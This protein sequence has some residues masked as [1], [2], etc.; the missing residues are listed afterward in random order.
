MRIL[1]I[2]PPV[3][4]F[5]YTPVR[6]YPLNLLYLGTI[7]VNNGFEI[8]I[9]NVPFE[10]SRKILSLPK[11]FQYLK[12][13]YKLNIS[14]FRLFHN[15]YRFGSYDY[16][17]NV[18][19]Q[20]RPQIVGISANFTA[21][22]KEALT[23]AE[24]IKHINKNV[25]IVIGGRAAT[26]LSKMFLD[27]ETVDFVIRGEAE[28]VFLFLCDEIKRKGYLTEY[29]DG[30]CT[31]KRNKIVISPRSVFIPCLDTLPIVNRRL[32]NYRLYRFRGH[33]FTSIIATRGCNFRCY[34]CGIKEPFRYRKIESIISEMEECYALGIRYF[35]FE[36]DNLN[37]HPQ[38]EE[39]IDEIIYRFGGGG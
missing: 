11:E 38:I 16:I 30:L 12:T 4:D 32:I 36:D 1:L 23:V 27:N 5:F 9:I 28:E 26:S 37:L 18:F 29:I 35:N 31:K 8:R 2:N 22:F 33:I 39:L 14:P 13:Y 7:L 25:I 21:Y 24:L 34:F 3:E 6:S 19:N 15:Y 10:S 17:V 20:F